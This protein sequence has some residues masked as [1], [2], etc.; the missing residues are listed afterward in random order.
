MHSLRE[1][2]NKLTARRQ[3]IFPGRMKAN[4]S[5]DPVES[6]SLLEFDNS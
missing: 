6:G 5:M 2:V 1:S 3:W 4:I